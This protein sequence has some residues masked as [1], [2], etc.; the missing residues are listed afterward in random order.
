MKRLLGVLLGICLLPLLLTVRT[1]HAE[2]AYP[3]DDTL[4]ALFDALGT[5]DILPDDLALDDPGALTSLR[6]TDVLSSLWDDVRAGMGTPVRTLGLLLGTIG[7]A[8]VAG[9]L[10]GEDSAVGT[11]YDAVC[12]LCAVSITAAPL[13]DGFLHATVLLARAA[14]FLLAFSGVLGTVLALGGGVTTAA[15]YQT[16]IAAVCQ[17]TMQLTANVLM[18]L[19]SMCMAMAIVDALNTEI[20]LAGIL[21]LFHKL[22]CW[23]LGLVMAL[24]LGMLSVQ[25]M[26]AAAADRAGTKAARYVISGA[27]PIIGSAVSDAYTAVIGSLGV[28]RAAVGMV[29]IAALLSLLAPVLIELGLQRLLLAVAAA[30][31]ELFGV[32]RLQRLFT[33]MERVTAA[34]FSAAVSFSVIAVFSTAVMLLIG[35][36]G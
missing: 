24:F 33:N 28:L 17:L 8:A 5:E 9:S 12:V 19:L 26:V 27:V 36:N 11:V 25:S 18:P 21:G 20:S 3:P 10:R 15:V 6:F 32:T 22:V 35:G 34:G 31:A 29:G 16:G 2:E 30:A 13:A 14:D 1:V 23:V 4:A 7:L